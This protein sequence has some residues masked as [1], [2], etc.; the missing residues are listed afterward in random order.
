[1]KWRKVKKELSKRFLEKKKFDTER[2][3]EVKS[4]ITFVKS[5][6]T[7]MTKDFNTLFDCYYKVYE[8]QKK[9]S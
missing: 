8:K 4:F 1:M 2:Y 5:N 7:F 3:Y 9:D 6:K